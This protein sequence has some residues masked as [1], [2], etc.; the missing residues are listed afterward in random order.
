MRA[1]NCNT[2]GSNDRTDCASFAAAAV[3]CAEL[4]SLNLAR[5][6]IV[7]VPLCCCRWQ[8]AMACSGRLGLPTAHLHS[9]NSCHM[10][11]RNVPKKNTQTMCCWW[12]QLGLQ[13]PWCWVRSAACQSHVLVNLTDACMRICSQF[14][15]SETLSN[16][17]HC[18]WDMAAGSLLTS[19]QA[20][21]P[22]SVIL[23]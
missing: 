6:H 20:L 23:H 13:A 3:T 8:C 12:A 15:A 1:C 19:V 22:D 11:P 16:I 21:I 10:P 9:L 4:C 14:L 7:I 2:C 18:I 5:P 17:I